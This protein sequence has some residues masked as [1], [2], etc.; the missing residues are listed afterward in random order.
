LQL[1]EPAFSFCIQIDGRPVGWSLVA[2]TSKDKARSASL[3]LVSL[4]SDPEDGDIDSDVEVG[5]ES[6][7]KKI[8]W[9]DEADDGGSLL[10]VNQL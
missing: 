2:T 7:V 1:T 3:P 10:E 9:A 4:L 5:A 6:A 8:R